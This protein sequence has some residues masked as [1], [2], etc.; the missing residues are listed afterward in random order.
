L[1]LLL[2]VLVCLV[3]L[4][5]LYLSSRYSYLLFHSVVE[6]FS[7][8]VACAIFVIAWNSRQVWENSYFLLLGIAYLVV[9]ATDLVHTLAYKGMG[10]FQTSG[11]SDMAVQLWVAARYVE[12]ASL[13]IAPIVMTR[14]L[15]PYPILLGYLGVFSLVVVSIFVWGIFPDCFIEGAGLTNFK[16]VSEG[17]ISAMLLGSIFFLWRRRNRFDRNV[18]LLLVSSAVVT[19]L[20]EFCFTRYKDVYGP[21]NLVGH[22]LKLVSFYLIYKAV[23]ET[24]LSRPYALLFRDLT[25]A[26]EDLKRIRDEQERIIADRTADLDRTIEE[27]QGEARERVKAEKMLQASHDF[28]EIAYGQN[29]M[30]PLLHEFA[31]EIKK[32]TGCEAVG[33]RITDEQSRIPYK[34]HLG[35]PRAFYDLESFLSLESDQCMCTRVIKGDIDPMMPFYTEGGSFHMNGTTRFLETI[36]EEEKLVTRNVCNQFGYESVVLTPIRY[37]REILGLIHIADRGENKVPIETVEAL[38]RIAVHLG[39]AIRRVLAERNLE[40][41]RRRLFSVLQMLPGYVALIASDHSVRFANDKFVELFGEPSSKPCYALLRGRETPCDICHMAAVLESHQPYE[42]ERGGTDGRTYHVWGYPFDDVDGTRLVLELGLDVTERKRLEGEVLRISE[43]EKRQIGRDLH[44]SLGS[45]L[46]GISCLSQVL[47]RRLRCKSLPEASEAAEIESLI[48]E[49]MN[50]TRSLARGLNP[51]GLHPDG[52][53][54]AVKELASDFERMF[55]V[56]CRFR[57]EKPVLVSDEIVAMHLYRIAQEAASNAVRHGRAEEVIISLESHDGKLVLSIEDD[58]IG[59]ADESVARSG[60]GMGLQIM[61]YR[62]DFIGA[63]MRVQPRG[64][65]GTQVICRL[66]QSLE[67]AE[68]HDQEI[69]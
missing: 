22:F 30:G 52:L 43:V 20:S 65:G 6:A 12:G 29:S 54:R 19:V 1:K 37:G 51:I 55:G 11:Q 36:P 62:A 17:V 27:L 45:T 13:L 49:S 60:D 9:G 8:V 32:L 64:E 25:L 53:M 66:A 46:G 42:W 23:I 59:L 57:C 4:G 5:G 39:T 16:I 31:S 24:G 47:H 68:P 26:Q 38:E 33:I 61:R 34:A 69:R 2:T 50:L 15:R 7:V 3:L 10:V 18:L 14:K 41:Q 58:G 67:T 40:H 44:D 56:R 35:F 28:L 63:A 48:A 21:E